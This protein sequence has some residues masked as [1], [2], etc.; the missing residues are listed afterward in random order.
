MNIFVLKTNI[1][2]YE[3]ALKLNM[4]AQKRAAIEKLLAEASRELALAEATLRDTP[5]R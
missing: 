4:D 1:A 5:R 2:H 3:V